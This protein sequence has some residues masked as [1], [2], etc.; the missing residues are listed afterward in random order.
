MS[1]GKIFVLL[2]RRDY[3][4]VED[5]TLCD[6]FIVLSIDAYWKIPINQA[7][8]IIGIYPSKTDAHNARAVAIKAAIDNAID[9]LI[10]AGLVIVRA[11][12]RIAL[13]EYGTQGLRP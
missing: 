10:D 3:L 1:A 4:T 8:E 6:S 12:G 7:F 9:E 2:R 11:D 5:V 13:A